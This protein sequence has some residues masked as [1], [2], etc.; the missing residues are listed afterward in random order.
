M[1]PENV[2]QQ[3]SYAFA[4]RI[5]KLYQ[6]LISTK[7]EYVLS[8]QILRSGTSIGA[9][10]EEAIGGQSKA[11]FIHKLS[12]AYK[13]ARETSYWLRLLKDTD[14]LTEKEFQSIHPDVEELCRII[15]SIQK[16]AKGNE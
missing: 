3:K 10:V 14:Y 7:K 8:K 2:V 5:V 4:V 13:E 16:S 1:K 15:G 12:I 11:D 9:N 6:Y